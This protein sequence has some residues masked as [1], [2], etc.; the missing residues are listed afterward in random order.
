MN[1]NLFE[2]AS[3][4]LIR[5][6]SFDRAA[7]EACMADNPGVRVFENCS[8][9]GGDFSRMDLRGLQFV[10]CT[11]AEASWYAADLSQTQWTGCRGRQADFESASMTDAKFVNCDLNNTKWRRAKLSSASFKGC[12]LT[13]AHFVEVAALGL[14]F[15]DCL[16]VGTDLRGLS[17]RKA[18]L[19]I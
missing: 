11:L 13:G 6:Q 3:D 8:F 19:R 14:G 18:Q 4:P 2:T 7:L 5:H 12:K 1:L 17:F 9:D 10:L 16:L 15:E